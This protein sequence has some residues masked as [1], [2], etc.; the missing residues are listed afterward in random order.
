MAAVADDVAFMRAAC[1]CAAR[2]VPAPTAYNVGAVL[3]ASDGRVLATG[4]S[5]ELPGNTH[6][7]ECAL[8]KAAGGPVTGS[9]L[10]T[11]MEPCSRRLS[12]N[13]PCVRRVIDAGVARVV[14][15]ILEPPRFVADC[16]G[17]EELRAAGVV[18][19]GDRATNGRSAGRISSSVSPWYTHP[20]SRRRA[21]LGGP[22]QVDVCDD[23]ECREAARAVNAHLLDAAVVGKDSLWLT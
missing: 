16:T 4:Y 21:C 15:A 5:R 3:V 8:R 20:L 1:A 6:A 2:C 23:A 22:T 9:T 11:T 14:L 10:Y 17:V 7:E 13:A 19:S 12:G 18:V